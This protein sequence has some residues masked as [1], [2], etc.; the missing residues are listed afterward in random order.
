M[1]NNYWMKLWFDILRDPK[2]GM[3]PDRLWRRVIEL[4]LLAGQNGEDGDLPDIAEIAWQLNKSIPAI[5]TDLEKIAETG[6]VEQKPDGSWF[7]TNFKKRNA[8]VENT[9]RVKDFRT[10][11]RYE[12]SNENVTESEK[13]CNAGETQVKR[14][15]NG[16][17]QVRYQEEQKNRL[18]DLTTTT[19]MPPSD[20]QPFAEVYELVTGSEPKVL[21]AEIEA[22][23]AIIKA[24][25]TP[26]DYRSALQGMQ[27][28]DY[29]I[30]NMSSAL[31][32][33][34]KDIENRKQPARINRVGKKPT[35]GTKDDTKGS[36]EYFKQLRKGAK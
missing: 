17:L 7:V 16:A 36:Y 22:I 24:G 19:T 13:K 34:L 10:R 29:T 35:G 25:G 6:I 15:C 14:E 28:K 23:S 27:D 1:K 9:K 3:L 8:P 31:T 4:F 12:I 11:E 20:F 26:D 18:T 5:K 21:N 32:W 30:A 2:M 33:T